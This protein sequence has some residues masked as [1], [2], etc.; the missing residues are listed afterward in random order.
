VAEDFNLE[1]ETYIPYAVVVTSANYGIAL[2]LHIASP[3]S[4]NIS[5]VMVLLGQFLPR[6]WWDATRNIV[7]ETER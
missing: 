3:W 5:I 4:I 2:S 7:E 6:V 1:H